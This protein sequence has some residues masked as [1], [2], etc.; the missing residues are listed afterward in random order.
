MNGEYVYLKKKSSFPKRNK[1]KKMDLI[2][3][4]PINIE[5]FKNVWFSLPFSWNLC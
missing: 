2:Y 3:N 4:L 1:Q 5:T